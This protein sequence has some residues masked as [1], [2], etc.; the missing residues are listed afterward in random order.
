[1]ID[2]DLVQRLRSLSNEVWRT[3]MLWPGFARQT[4]GSQ[5]VDC[6]DSIGANLVEGDGRATEPDAI[7]FF[8]ISRGSLR[9]AQFWLLLASDRDLIPHD[10]FLAHKEELRQLSLMLNA[11]IAYRQQSRTQKG[12]REELVPYDVDGDGGLEPRA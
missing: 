1:M 11:L 6:L 5:L 7:R 2:S 10:R 8:V 12:V 9:E 4:L 3:V